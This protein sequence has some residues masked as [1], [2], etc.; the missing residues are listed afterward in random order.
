MI[1][2]NNSN[3]NEKQKISKNNN[4]INNINNIVSSP[5]SGTRTKSTLSGN[6]SLFECNSSEDSNFALDEKNKIKNNKNEKGKKEKNIKIN[7]NFNNN[8]LFDNLL[9]DK[10]PASFAVNSR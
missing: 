7:N 6:I 8:N 3:N 1:F 5:L 4:N 2:S 10:S 9:N